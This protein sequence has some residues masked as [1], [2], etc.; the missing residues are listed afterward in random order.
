MSWLI[1]GAGGMLGRDLTEVLLA[2]GVEVTA[3]TRTELDITDPAAVRS[4]VAGHEVVLNAAAWTDVDGA[5]TDEAA[6]TRINGDGPRQL[7]RACAEQ[8]GTVLIQV[9]TDY[10]F[11]GDAGQPYRH[12]APTSPVNAYGR[13]KLAG[14]QAVAEVLPERGYTVRT[15]W[16]YGAHGRNFVSTMLGLAEQRETLDVVDDQRGQPTWTR[17]LSA[18]L[19]DLGVAALAGRAPA[20]AYHGTATDTATWYDLARAAFELTGL[21]PER[22]RPTT[23]EKFVRPA[24]RPAYS[25]LDHGRWAD[26]GVPVQPHWRVQLNEA[27]QSMKAGRPQA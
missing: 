25:V 27:L 2:R 7:A 5:E 9:S 15:A 18:Q 22:I 1:T 20:G 13:S 12:D 8:P 24:K 16:L 23:S 4:A 6:A 26:A 10:V 17:A 3:L 14:E 11:P 19:A 21:D